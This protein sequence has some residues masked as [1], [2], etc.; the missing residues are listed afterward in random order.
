MKMMKTRRMMRMLHGMDLMIRCWLRFSLGVL[1]YGISL[2]R[3]TLYQPTD[4]VALVLIRGSVR[5]T[6]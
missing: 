4:L 6:A 3:I 5:K 2:C 1:I